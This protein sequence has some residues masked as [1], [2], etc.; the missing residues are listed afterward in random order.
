ME[1]NLIK[2][3]ETLVQTIE[4]AVF[5]FK[6]KSQKDLEYANDQLVKITKAGTLLKN[7]KKEK[8]EPIKLQKSEIVDFF[9]PFE[10]KL[11]ELKG[12]LKK[13][14]NRYLIVMEKAQ[15]KKEEEIGEKILTGEIEVDKAEKKLEK[16]ES[17]KNVITVRKER[18]VEITD[19][20]KI[21]KK[22]WVLN[23]VDIRTDALSGK[24][25]EK[26]GIKVVEVRNI[27][28]KKN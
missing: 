1:T 5:N 22:Y 25:T 2:E 14:M 27:I 8:L 21:P 9:S 11:I 23:M 13:E 10:N 24:L 28:G 17:K 12:L 26:D 15:A 7:K 19:E 18:K 16:I 3:T 20:T 4:K 6:I